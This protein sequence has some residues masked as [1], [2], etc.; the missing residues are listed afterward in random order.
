MGFLG[1][2]GFLESNSFSSSDSAWHHSAFGAAI[3]GCTKIVTARLAKLRR[4]E[5]VLR[6]ALPKNGEQG[7]CQRHSDDDPDGDDAT[8]MIARDVAKIIGTLKLDTPASPA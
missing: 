3:G 5:V 6:V 2:G 4:P 8:H 7:V 1:T